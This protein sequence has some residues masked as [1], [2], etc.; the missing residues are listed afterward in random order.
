MTS[1]K[2]YWYV[3]QEIIL[4]CISGKTGINTSGIV[5]EFFW[6]TLFPMTSG[7]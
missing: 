3:F 7:R 5:R 6:S 4:H 1:Y 2:A